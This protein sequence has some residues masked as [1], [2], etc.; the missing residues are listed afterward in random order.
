MSYWCFLTKHHFLSIDQA[1]NALD[2]SQKYI[3]KSNPFLI[4]VSTPNCPDDLMHRISL[5]K[6]EDCIY[7]RLYLDYTVGL[8]RIFTDME[9]EVS[10][11]SSSFEREYALKF[12]GIEGNVFLQN[13]IDKA[14]QL[15]KELDA[16]HQVLARPELIPMTQFYIGVDPEFWQLCFCL[17][18][19]YETDNNLC[20]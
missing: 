8:G 19:D 20:T 12:L 3:A 7:K 18:V 13:K 6:E 10:K 2:T 15:G 16:Y 9:I 17:C 14:C 4:L 11:K 1:K 5:E